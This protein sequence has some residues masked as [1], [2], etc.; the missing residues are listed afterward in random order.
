MIRLPA[1]ALAA[2]LLLFLTGCIGPTTPV[3]T[4][5]AT[6]Q[7]PELMTAPAAGPYYLF[8]GA[9]EKKPIY[10]IDLKKNEKFGFV[11]KGTRVDAIAR[12]ILIE[13]PDRSE[14][15]KYTWRIPEKKDKKD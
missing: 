2:C 11:N 9:E 5:E 1:A 15:V 3:L 4:L 6:Q 10:Q 12:G 8:A 7:P 13:L 14:G